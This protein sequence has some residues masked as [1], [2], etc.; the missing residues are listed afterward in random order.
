MP[1]QDGDFLFRRVVLPL[2]AD[3]FAPLFYAKKRKSPRPV[4]TFKMPSDEAEM[5]QK[6][7]TTGSCYKDN[8]HSLATCAAPTK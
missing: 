1:P 3:A 8:E 6:L 4:A 7:N 2:L 5:N